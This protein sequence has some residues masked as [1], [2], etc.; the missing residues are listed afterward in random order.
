M[1]KIST[2]LGCELTISLNPLPPATR[3]QSAKVS[4]RESA[5]RQTSMLNDQPR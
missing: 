2:A 4:Y 5:P 1:V 3:Q